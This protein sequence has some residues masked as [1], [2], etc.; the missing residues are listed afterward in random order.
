[1]SYRLLKIVGQICPQLW[2]LGLRHEWLWGLLF[3]PAQMGPP[4]AKRSGVGLS[5]HCDSWISCCT[6]ILPGR[7]TAVNTT[8]RATVHTRGGWHGRQGRH[9]V[10]SAWSYKPACC[11]R[12]GKS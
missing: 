10:K 7:D 12:G 3:Q 1:L 6:A 4:A 8:S 9:F 5:L 2:G 11:A